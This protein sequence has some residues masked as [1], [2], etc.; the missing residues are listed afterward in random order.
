VADVPSA[1]HENGG[2][3]G[4]NTRRQR[5][6]T[7]MPRTDYNW[8]FAPYIKYLL[9]PI[10]RSTDDDSSFIKQVILGR[11]N[12]L[13]LGPVN[14]CSTS[15]AQSF[16]ISGPDG[17][18]DQIDVRSGTAY[19]FGNGASSL[20]RGWVDLSEQVPHLMHRNWE[21]VYTHT[22]S[23][24]ESAFVLY[25]RHKCFVT[26]PRRISFGQVIYRTAINADFCRR[27]SLNL[28]Y[29]S[30]MAVSHF[31]GFRSDH[32]K[33]LAS[34]TSYAWLLLVQLQLHLDLDDFGWL[35]PVSCIILS[36]NCI[37]KEFSNPCA[38][39]GPVY[40][41]RCSQQRGEI[42]SEGTAFSR[43]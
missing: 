1:P 18:H 13:G 39:R 25:G 42:G 20:A 21:P 19:K 34:Y 22:H 27:L 23:I 33:A 11:S 41:C 26:L 4:E 6:H 8:N 16:L 29:H 30:E 40:A 5:R 12:R 3:G 43:G 37:R 17:S 7:Y 35:L 10:D 36:F 9:F 14:C 32:C 24:H 31:N 15:P 2:G 28:F 38:I